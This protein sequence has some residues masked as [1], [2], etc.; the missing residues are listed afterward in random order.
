MIIL[1]EINDDKRFN[2]VYKL[3]K[4]SIPSLRKTI[5]KR[6]PIDEITIKRSVVITKL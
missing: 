2:K 3:L 1:L 5:N 6:V 4:K